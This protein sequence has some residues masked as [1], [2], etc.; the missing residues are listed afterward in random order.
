[1]Y[2]R[3]LENLL[4]LLQTSRQSGLLIV[5]SAEPNGALWQGQLMIA[6]GMVRACQVL[7][8][9]DR[10]LLYTNEEALRW[11]IAQGKLNWN[12]E[13][14]VLFPTAL[15]PQLQQS[16]RLADERKDETGPHNSGDLRAARERPGWIPRRTAKGLQF[17][18]KSLA[19]IEHLQVFTLVNGQNTVEGISRLLRKPPET[20]LRIL[21]ELRA[22]G[23]IE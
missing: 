8:K 12:L 22:S 5:E 17:S 1:V 18:G 20:I 16:G 13:K 11:L 6:D 23:F 19:S 21:N 7:R 3:N 9:T 15:S 14:D 2:T 4:R 10:Q